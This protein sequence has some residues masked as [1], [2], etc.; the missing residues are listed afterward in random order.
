MGASIFNGDGVKILKDKLKFKTTGSISWDANNGCPSYPSDIVGVTNQIGQETH[1]RVYNNTGSIIP[2][3]SIVYVSGVNV[4]TGL[5][6]VSLAIANNYAASRILGLATNAIGIGAIGIITREGVVHDLNTIAYNPGDYLYLSDT[7]PG[8]WTPTQPVDGSYPCRIG[9]VLMKSATVGSIL[10]FHGVDEHTVETTERTGWSAV[11]APASLSFVDGVG[12][13]TRTLTLSP[14]IGTTFHFYQHGVKYT[15]L[16]DSFKIADTEGLH[17]IYY[18]LGVLAEIINPTDAQIN[19]TIINNPLVAYVYWDAANKVSNFIGKETHGINMSVET[20]NYLHFAFGARYLNGLALNSF[21]ADG[22]GALATNIQFGVDEGAIADEDI[23]HSVTPIASTVGLPIYYLAGTAAAPMLR[24]GTNAGYS[25]IATGTGRIAYNLLTGGNWTLAEVPSTDL[26]LYHIF[27]IGENLTANRVVAFMGQSIY[28]SVANARAGAL[29]EIA[30]IQLIPGLPKEMKS[31]G[32]IIYETNNSYSNALKSRIRTISPGVNYQDWRAVNT[33][34][35]S[36]AGGPTPTVFQDS[37]FQIFDNTDTTKTFQFEA[38]NITTATNK[39]VTISDRNLTLGQHTPWATAT[40][41]I[42]NDTIQIENFAYVCVVDHISAAAFATDRTLGYWKI[43]NNT[44]TD[45]I[46]NYIPTPSAIIGIGSWKVFKETDAVTFQDTGDTVTLNAHGM[47]SGTKISFTSITS[48]TGISA[49]TTYYVVTPTTNT[50]QV[51]TS[52]GGTA[53]TLT[54]DGS[55]TLVRAVPKT[56]AVSVADV[57]FARNT[58]SPLSISDFL[59][60]KDAANRMGQGISIDFTIAPKHQSTILQLIFNHL[61]SANYVDG[62]MR[63][64]LRDLTNSVNIEFTDRDLYGYAGTGSARA[65]F[66]AQTSA[67]SVSY[68]LIGIIGSVN[69]NAYTIKFD[70]F[71][72]G[73]NKISSGVIDTYLG[74]LTTTGSWTSNTTYTFNYWRRGDKLIAEGVIRT[75]GT[76][77]TASLS[78]NLPSGLSIDTN[79]INVS[80]DGM[81]LGTGSINGAGSAYYNVRLRGNNN[82]SAIR[83]MYLA[84]ASANYTNITQAAPFAF[85]AGNEVYAKYEVPIAGW[86]S[87]TTM[88]ED[89]GNRLIVG[90]ISSNDQTGINPNN[91]FVKVTLNLIIRDTTNSHDS[92]NSRYIIPESGDYHLDSRV[93]IGSTNVLNSG[94]GLNIFRNGNSYILGERSIPKAATAFAVIATGTKYFNKGDIV[95]LYLYGEG[96]NSSSTIDIGGTVQF[97]IFKVSSPQTIAASEKCYA[98]YNTNT[99]TSVESSDSN[100]SIPFEDKVVDSHNAYNTT[101]GIYTCPRSGILSLSAAIQLASNAGWGAGEYAQLYITIGAVTLVLQEIR[102]QATVNPFVMNLSGSISSFLV[103]K[104]DAVIIKAYQNSGGAISLS[105]N[106]VK[107]HMEIKID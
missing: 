50:F 100:V 13:A 38:S 76:P 84:Q 35:G 73:P 62:D 37:T 95:E 15:K 65:K 12:G 1:V 67:A 45:S 98:V 20:H 24:K 59:F 72:F 93:I 90:D 92:A 55:G 11:Y 107:N 69:A 91:S 31:L 63:F 105:A 66:D 89:V 44:N 61:D 51:A 56:G 10:V 60:T 29:V 78:I 86:S 97:M 41:Y 39:I 46:I 64:Y 53:L 33:T 32:T 96:N 58:T 104:G 80:S 83:L 3:G 71:Q 68:R 7:I 5:P 94:Y 2:D 8:A 77:T 102:M 40:H 17:F 81:N 14:V 70:S 23:Y 4:G 36:V 6:E 82:G 22:T 99:A 52:A 49:N 101:T 85:I 16:T 25:A 42:V 87:N 19:S 57:T 79:K 48:T 75:S 21:V 43:L 18:N 74:V 88:S 27:C 103:N 54:T 9:V 26:C 106:A 30:Q 47:E 34:G 28:T